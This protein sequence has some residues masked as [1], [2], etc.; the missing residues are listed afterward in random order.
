MAIITSGLIWFDSERRGARRVD[1][2][3]R[4]KEGESEADRER[5]IASTDFPG[6]DEQRKRVRE[7]LRLKSA[8]ILSGPIGTKRDGARRRMRMRIKIEKH[9]AC[10]HQA[11]HLQIDELQ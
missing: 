4:Q 11:F 3:K 10:N 2:R 1:Q 7:S 9:S 6:E 5:S 8:S